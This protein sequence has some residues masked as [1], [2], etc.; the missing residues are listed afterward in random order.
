MSGA[1]NERPRA[2]L[3][4]RIYYVGIYCD[5]CGASET[6][7]VA[8]SDQGAAE[9]GLRVELRGKGWACDAAGD[10]CPRCRP[11]AA[12]AATGEGVGFEEDVTPAAGVGVVVAA[13]AAEPERRVEIRRPG[14]ADWTKATGW[15]RSGLAN[16]QHE[17]AQWGSE[18]DVR[19]VRVDEDGTR[20]PECWR[21][22]RGIPDRPWDYLPGGGM[23]TYPREED[24]PPTPRR[25][26]PP[27][28][29]ALR[30]IDRII[31]NRVHLGPRSLGEVR[32]I[33][34]DALNAWHSEELDP[35]AVAA[36]AEE[37]DQLWR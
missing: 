32:G 11:A 17:A 6:G 24:V 22:A 14:E 5:R 10:L 7:D 19:V 18:V 36:V 33:V 35:G 34:L 23:A 4:P 37:G 20:V 13:P 2:P 1:A 16:V 21:A 27:E 29:E 28:V 26:G 3:W 25:T 31:G 15:R 30:A 9:D 8:G 12:E